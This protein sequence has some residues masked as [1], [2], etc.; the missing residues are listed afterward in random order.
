MV[1]CPFSIV[2]YLT[3]LEEENGNLSEVEVDE[4]L[5]FVCDVASEVSAD[6][7]VPRWVVLLVELFLDVGCDVL[8]DVV[9][10]HGLGSTVYCVLLHVLGHIG[11]L[12]YCF[13]L[14]HLQTTKVSTCRSKLCTKN[15]SVQ[16][17][18]CCYGDRDNSEYVTSKKNF[19]IPR[20]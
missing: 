14:S 6:D 18:P 2:Y 11:I 16:H 13:P 8:F 12:N 20:T 5:R 19:R 3:G 10:L 17:G 9:L 15:L 4:M 1:V 7:C